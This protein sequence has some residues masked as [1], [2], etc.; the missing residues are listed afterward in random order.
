MFKV[1][2]S[3]LLL[4]SS[5]LTVITPTMACKFIPSA[6]P[7]GEPDSSVV[8]TRS[9]KNAKVLLYTKNGEGFVHD[10]IPAAITAIKNL[11]VK[12]QFQVDVSDNPSVFSKDN[13][14][15]YALLI[16]ASTN[17]DVFDTD[18]QRLAFRRYIQAGGGLVGIHSV[19]GTERNWTWFKQMVGGTFSWHPPI[20]D[21]K[22]VNIRPAHPSVASLPKEWVINDECYF[23]KELYPGIRVLMAH[24]LT[25]LDS[26]LRSDQAELIRKH[27]AHFG[28]LYPAV[29]HQQF[30]G[31][32]VWIT[33][34]GHAK[35]SYNDPVFMRHILKGIEYV[36]RHSSALDYSKA[37]A[38][39]RD[40][41]VRY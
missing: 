34:L 21:I 22:V 37:Y 39:D 25:S 31:G 7:T 3:L 1:I 10:N 15:Q 35:E 18:D 16:F 2:T 5:L 41:A 24:D 30:D 36:V 32:H 4:F 20:Q 27:S 13:L 8:L 26:T 11:G 6:Q 38:A 9:L 14:D 33:T 17:N 40:D 23:L 19:T 12:H 29:W 28:Q